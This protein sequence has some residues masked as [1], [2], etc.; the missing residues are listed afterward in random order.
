MFSYVRLYEPVEL[1]PRS[2][3]HLPLLSTN[4][5]VWTAVIY[6]SR[7]ESNSQIL[8][9]G[10]S[11]YV[12]YTTKRCIETLN[13]FNGAFQQIV[14]RRCKAQA[15]NT[16]SKPFRELLLEKLL[17]VGDLS[18][19]GRGIIVHFRNKSIG[20]H[21]VKDSKIAMKP[22]NFKNTAC[23]PSCRG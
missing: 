6:R 8:G 20:S 23:G 10:F 11:G 9:F 18:R 19:N 3:A 4:R 14:S 5:L 21:S 12:I 15:Q 17:S 13:T 7:P 16:G 2:R 1:Q 22:R